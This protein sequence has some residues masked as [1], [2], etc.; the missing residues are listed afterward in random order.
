MK[1]GIIT[2]KGKQYPTRTF[3]IKLNDEDRTQEVTISVESLSDAMG[4]KKE[5]D[6]TK[7]QT[8]DNTIYYYVA[9]AVINLSDKEIA[10]FHL[11]AGYVLVAELT[12]IE[13]ARKDLAGKDLTELLDEICVQLIDGNDADPVHKALD[14]WH[15][16]SNQEG[17]IAFFGTEEEAFRYRLD[18]INRVLNG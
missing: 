4:G 11:D 9:D 8:I 2:Y 3:T 7:E 5:K 14:G 16:V 1:T 10:S 12:R 6:G 18:F 17:L 13:Q 15:G